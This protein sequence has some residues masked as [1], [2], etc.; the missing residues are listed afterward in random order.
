MEIPARGKKEINSVHA[1]KSKL[2]QGLK[3]IGGSPLSR[4]NMEGAAPPPQLAGL[5]NWSGQPP[6][7]HEIAGVAL[8]TK[9]DKL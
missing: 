4:P 3:I 5:P 8:P 9:L 7:I 2:R 1:A 6:D